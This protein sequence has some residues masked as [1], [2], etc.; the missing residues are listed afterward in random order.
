LATSQSTLASTGQDGSPIGTLEDYYI[1]EDGIVH[2]VFSNSLNRDLGQLVLANFVNQDGLVEEA[3]NLYDVTSAS[4]TPI[5]GA[6]G[7]NGTGRTIGQALE[8]S[9]VDLSQEFITLINAT[10]G[11]SANSRVFSTSD[12]LIQELL[13]TLG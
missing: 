5:L 1:S 10:T 13:N 2:G 9:N 12:Q 6:P 11:Y 7:T 3:G 8:L 4:G